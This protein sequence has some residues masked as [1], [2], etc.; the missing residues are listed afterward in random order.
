MTTATQDH[1][2]AHPRTRSME[3]W[4]ARLGA[5]ASRGEVDG[6]RVE[7]CKTALAFWRTRSFLVREMGLSGER[8]DDLL[9][10][11]EDGA[12]EARTGAEA[13]TE[14]EAVSA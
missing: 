5:L 11:I 1:I 14:A 10:Q 13:P 3:G 12:E 7:E 2:A 4:R 9:D 8:A 6:P